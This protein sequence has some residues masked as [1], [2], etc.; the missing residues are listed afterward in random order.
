MM[1]SRFGSV[2]GKTAKVVSTSFMSQDVTDDQRITVL[3]DGI[4]YDVGALAIPRKSLGA[5]GSLPLIIL[6]RDRVAAAFA[7]A[8]RISRANLSPTVKSQLIEHARVR[9]LRDTTARTRFMLSSVDSIKVETDRIR[10]IGT[11]SFLT[12]EAPESIERPL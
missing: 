4:T 7:D 12:L 3:V 2:A 10:I 8:P 9:S 1:S 11:C 5:K 6:V